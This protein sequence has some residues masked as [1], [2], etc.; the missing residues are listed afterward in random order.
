MIGR[1]FQIF[2]Q[3][4]R[5]YIS[6]S[7]NVPTVF[8]CASQSAFPPWFFSS[9]PRLKEITHSAPGSIFQTSVPPADKAWGGTMQT[10]IKFI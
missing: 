5:K 6:E 4:T 1:N 3:I 10:I 9:P 7:Q 2:I 8:T